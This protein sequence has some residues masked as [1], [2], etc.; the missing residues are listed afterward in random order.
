MC[1]L[2]FIPVS[3]TDFIFTTNRD[4]D[5]NRVALK[6]QRYNHQGHDLYY[7]KDSKANGSWIISNSVDTTLCLL[8]G[9]FEKHQR[10][11]SYRQSRGDVA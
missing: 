5:P 9:A 4:E 11:S 3:D 2:S 6:P 7:P 1:T 8:N 10:Q